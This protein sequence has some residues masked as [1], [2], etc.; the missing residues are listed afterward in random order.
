MILQM[1]VCLFRLDLQLILSLLLWIG[2]TACHS[3]PTQAPVRAA[4]IF[5]KP[6]RS[7]LPVRKDRTNVKRI[8][9]RIIMWVEDRERGGDWFVLCESSLLPFDSSWVQT[10]NEFQC[11][12]SSLCCSLSTFGWC[13]WWHSDNN[14]GCSDCEDCICGTGNGLVLVSE[15]GGT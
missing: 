12:W 6:A 8:M 7:L 11:F 14:W 1:S 13:S 2:Q 9:E 10:L 15:W 3:H 5:F 4:C